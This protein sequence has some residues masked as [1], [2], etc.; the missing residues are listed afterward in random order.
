MTANNMYWMKYS[1][2]IA[3][4]RAQHDLRVGAVLVSNHNELLCSAYAGEECDASWCSVLLDKVRK[5]RIESA[6]SIYI[7]INTLLEDNSFD[8]IKLLREVHINEIYIG[9]PDPAL[10]GYL[11]G[12]PVTSCCHVCRY[13]DELQRE[14]LEQNN[15]IFSDSE[16]SI[17]HNSYYS[18]NRISKLVIERL[19]SNGFAVSKKD[20]KANKQRSALASLIS[21]RYGVEYSKAMAAVNNAISDAFNTKYGSYDYTNDTRSLDSGWMKSFLSIFERTSARAMSTIDILNIGVG[22]G[23]E[24]LALFSNCE[25]VTFVDIAQDG[26][27]KIKEQIPLSSTVVSSANDL[28]SIPDNSYDLYVSLRTYNSSFFDIKEAILEAHRVLKINAAII[29]SVANGFLDSERHRIIPGLIIPGTE[30]V[31]IYRGMDTV[32][33]I[34]KEMIQAGFKNIQL[35]PTNTE[36]FLSAITI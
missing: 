15:L 35:Y 14:I 20:L 8:M 22:S 6:E 36:I 34:R 13:P 3:K 9:L 33:L 2:N 11:D 26:L 1:I 21:K 24:A 19:L 29:L 17:K 23:H 4:E 10:T 25:S 18:N 27:G 7:T 31:D 5:L 30:F 12:D 28:S 32:E 16:Q